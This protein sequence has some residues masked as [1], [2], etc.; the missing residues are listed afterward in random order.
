MV[1]LYLIYF[2]VLGTVW[3]SALSPVSGLILVLIFGILALI[4]GLGAAW[5]VSWLASRRKVIAN[6]QQVI[7]SSY[8]KYADLTA[9]Y[10]EVARSVTAL[11]Q[12]M[13]KAGSVGEY[14]LPGV[15]AGETKPALGTYGSEIL[16]QLERLDPTV[17]RVQVFSRLL[18]D[19]PVDFG[20]NKS[21]TA[22]FIDGLRSHYPSL[23]EGG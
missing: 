18:L 23:S 1:P 12:S 20:R 15:L 13:C 2:I 19:S 3:S 17:T 16:V 14:G 22:R 10:D 8:W 9:P 4:F 21:L 7:G 11:L 6:F 5:Y